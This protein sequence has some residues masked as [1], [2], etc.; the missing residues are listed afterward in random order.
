MTTATSRTGS[1][2][3]T[4]T[5]PGPAGE[6]SGRALAVREFERLA[7]ARLD[8]AHYDYFAGGAGD[9]VTLRANEA[10]FGRLAL[11]PRVLRGAAGPDLGVT[12][13]GRRA[14]TPV[15]VAPTAFH[16]LAHPDGERATARAAAA[17]GT[18]MIVSMAATVAVEDVAAAAP[19]AELWF[20]LYAQSDAAFTEAVVRRA[21]AAGCSALVVTAD[22]PARGRRERELRRGFTDLPDGLRCEN[23][24]DGGRVRPIEMWPGLSWEHL[25][26]LRRITALPIVLKGVLHPDDARRA[27]GHGVAALLVSNH[28]G[29]QLD[30]VPATIDALPEI[31]AAVDGAVPVLLDGGIRR[32]TDVLKALALGADAVAVG[33]PV[34]WGL[35]A[36]GERGV[37]RVLGLLRDE[38][39]QALTLCGCASVRDLDPGMVRRTC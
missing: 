9:E 21:E 8:P 7:R 28:G 26:F 34:I 11:L 24:R 20:Q 23:L 13:L 35:A 1:G 14:A 39:E 10:A 19:D 29:R 18:I 16:R 4:G 25:A 30:S 32:G 12:L 15:L 22:S 38:V 17:A 3:G 37:A 6:A 31:A 27:L 5:D 33:R 36:D 2:N